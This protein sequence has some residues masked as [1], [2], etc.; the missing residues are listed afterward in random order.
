MY[1]LKNV[2]ITWNFIILVKST[3]NSTHYFLAFFN[4]RH[5]SVT[6]LHWSDTYFDLLSWR[7][8]EVP[9][10][11]VHLFCWHGIK[12]F[13]MHLSSKGIGGYRIYM[14]GSVSRFIQGFTEYLPARLYSRQQEHIWEQNNLKFLSWLTMIKCQQEVRTRKELGMGHAGSGAWRVLF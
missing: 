2:T 1:L 6:D 14:E 7:S 9:Q 3:R 8:S 4:W 12:N 5:F 11:I 13:N 10:V